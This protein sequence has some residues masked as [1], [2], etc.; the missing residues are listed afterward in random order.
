MRPVAGGLPL[1]FYPQPE[2]WGPIAGWEGIYDVSDHGRIRVRDR[3]VNGAIRRG[4]IRKLNGEESRWRPAVTL[5]AG[6]R[7]ERRVVH[8]L[9]LDAFVGPA[10]TGHVALHWND[11]PQ[12]NRLANLRWGTRSD[13][14]RDALRNGRLVP[15]ARP[16]GSGRAPSFRSIRQLESGSY[17]ARY[18]PRGRPHHS[19]CFG[20]RN[21]AATLLE[22]VAEI[23]S[24]SRDSAEADQRIAILFD[25]ARREHVPPETPHPGRPRKSG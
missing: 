21:D 15:S 11:D 19:A 6:E 8:R 16:E 23:E 4:R 5:V 25:A 2:A 17:Q 22:R 7:M 9:V 12:D 20:S 24:V 3:V 13:N 10:P 14:A 18:R 1:G